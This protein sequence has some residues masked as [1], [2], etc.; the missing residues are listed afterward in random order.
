MILFITS[1]VGRPPPIMDTLRPQSILK[2]PSRSQ[3]IANRRPV[4]R[5]NTMP[6]GEAAKSILFQQ[7]KRQQ[8]QDRELLKE[9]WRKRHSHR[10]AELET[11]SRSVSGLSRARS[12]LNLSVGHQSDPN[13]FLVIPSQRIKPRVCDEVPDEFK[14]AG[15]GLCFEGDERRMKSHPKNTVGNV[16]YN[17]YFESRN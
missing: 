3:Q 13:W 17:Y 4:K 7:Y 6:T 10:T 15:I 16:A 12:D 5:S 8:Q 14:R 11:V 2:T 1:S 9:L